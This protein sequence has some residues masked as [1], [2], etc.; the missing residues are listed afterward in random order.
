M[1]L[2]PEL[3]LLSCVWFWPILLQKSDIQE[4]QPVTAQF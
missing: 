3:G 2:F 4:R 1:L